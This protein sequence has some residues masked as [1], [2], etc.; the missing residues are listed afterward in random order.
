MTDIAL[1]DCAPI[2]KMKLQLYNNVIERMIND[3]TKKLALALGTFMVL[4]WKM[5][6]QLYISEVERTVICK[7]DQ[8]LVV[9]TWQSDCEFEC[10]FLQN[11]ASF[12]CTSPLYLLKE[13]K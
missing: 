8:P 12:L 7:K 10:Q 11:Y 2:W 6:Q 3:Q 5:K 4:T 1:G 9:G 13:E